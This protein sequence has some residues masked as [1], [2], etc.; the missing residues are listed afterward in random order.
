[1]YHHVQ[2]LESAK[3][4]N[5]L[6]LTVSTETFTNQMKY[7]KEKGYHT[8]YPSDLINFFDQSTPVTSKS[9]M[10]TFDDG[11]DDFA[12]NALPILRSQGFTSV[13]FIPTGLINNGGYLSWDTISQVASAGDVMFA[14]HTWSHRNVGS[15]TDAIKSEITTADTQLIER[16]LNSPKIFAYPY[17]LSSS[18][19]KTVLEGLGYKLA[20]STKP[21]STQCKVLRYELTRIRIGNV[22]ISRY[23]F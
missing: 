5:Q 20:Y 17:G 3:T 9:I 11:Y 22:D 1:M 2:D 12:N 19:S 15:N 8:I 23:G 4:K 10:I 13:V 7:L 14:N 21:G 6:S 16:N 18:Y